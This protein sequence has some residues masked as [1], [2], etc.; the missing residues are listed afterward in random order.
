MRKGF[1]PATSVPDGAP[2]KPS[3]LENH[4]EKALAGRTFPNDRGYSHAGLYIPANLLQIR[5]YYLR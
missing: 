1:L 4:T 5:P 3:G 2:P